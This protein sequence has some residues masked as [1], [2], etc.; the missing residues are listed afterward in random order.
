MERCTDTIRTGHDPTAIPY[1]SGAASSVAL[2]PFAAGTGNPGQPWCRQSAIARP[3]LVQCGV[4]LLELMIVVVIVG[5]LAVIAVPGYRGYAQRA[6]RTEAKSALLRLA[7]NQE[8]WYL[9]HNTYTSSLADLGFGGNGYT[10]NGVYTL[11]FIVTPSTT[12]FTAR[13]TPTPGGGSNGVDQAGDSDCAEF[14]INEQGVRTATP[15][16]H[17]TCW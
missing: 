12:E 1:R 2:E 13:A 11:D 7:A 6:H 5:V 15:D 16:P 3:R 14:T 4:T 8:R 9:Q 10:E 17:G